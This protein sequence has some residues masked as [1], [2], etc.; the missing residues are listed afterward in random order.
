V[1]WVKT[2]L[3]M[4]LFFL[5]ILFSIQNQSQ[6]TLHFAL[7]PIENFQWF[8]IPQTPL[9]LFLVI[10]CSIFLGIL[11]GGTGDLYQRFR[12][13][14]TLRQSQKTITKLEKEIQS[15][16]GPGLDQPS[17]LKKEG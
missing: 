2:L 10:L 8:E 1:R 6:V 5:A 13:K 4:L 12:I 14:R 11:I 9:P 17:F 16:R 7:F 15:L 3:L